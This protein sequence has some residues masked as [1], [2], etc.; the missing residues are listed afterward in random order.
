MPAHDAERRERDDERVRHAPVDVDEPVDARRP[1]RPCRGSRRSTSAL[2]LVCSKTIAPTTPESAIVEP[3]ERS[4]PRVMIT[5]S[6]PS[7]THG[8]HRGLREDVADVAAREED[9]RRQADDDDQQEQ[10]QRRARRAAR[11]ASPAAGGSGRSRSDRAACARCVRLRAPSTVISPPTAPSSRRPGGPGGKL[12]LVE[13]RRQH[14][15]A[16]ARRRRRDVAAVARRRPDRGSARAGG[17]P[18]RP[19]GPRASR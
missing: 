18:T 9:R 12:E 1:R 2:E 6:W 7:A 14:L 3:T 8:D 4:M 5:S 17:R 13:R 19:P 15:D 11:A 16:V 10:D